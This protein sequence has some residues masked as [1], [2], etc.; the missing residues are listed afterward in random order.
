MTVPLPLG[1]TQQT[2]DM[3]Q[4]MQIQGHMLHKMTGKLP[5][6]MCVQLYLETGTKRH[7]FW[8]EYLTLKSCTCSTEATR[9][10]S[11][12]ASLAAGLAATLAGGLAAL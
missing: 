6:G 2:G 3:N 1:G 8:R 10:G 12:A 7:F 9:M 4:D 5:V 11:L